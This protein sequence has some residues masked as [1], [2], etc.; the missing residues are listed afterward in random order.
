MLPSTVKPKILIIDDDPATLLALPEALRSRFPDVAID[1]ASSAESAL[2]LIQHVNYDVIVSDIIMPGMDGIQLLRTA[3]KVRP[4]LVIVMV[5]AGDLG[6][7][8]EAMHH[9]AFAFV[10]KPFE[11]DRFAET[12]S[13]GIQRARALRVDRGSSSQDKSLT[14]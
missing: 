13:T 6:R 9:G 14:L 12:I 4:G 10:A 1:V 2:P 8:Q 3:L 5:T 11:V 7:E